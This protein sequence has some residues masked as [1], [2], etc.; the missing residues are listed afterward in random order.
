MSRSTVV[1]VM[2]LKNITCVFDAGDIRHLHLWS[3]VCLKNLGCWLLLSVQ[4]MEGETQICQEA[5]VYA[6]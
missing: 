4:R 2:Y 1:L 3:R 5:F 6:G